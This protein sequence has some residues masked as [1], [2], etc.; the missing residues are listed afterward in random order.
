MGIRSVFA[1]VLLGLAAPA[2]GQS[3]DQE[4]VSV[5]DSPDPV[6]PGGNITYTVTIRNNGP[7]A[8][9][10]GGLNVNLSASLAYV[11]A[12][13]P[14]G[15]SCFALGNNLSCTAPSFAP[16][17][18]VITIVAQ[19]PASLL[20]FPDGTVTSNF[21]TSGVTLDPNIGN[22]Q[23]SSTTDY[24]SP[25]VDLSV[26]VTD[27]PDPVGPNQNL[28]YT[29]TAKNDGPNSAT[30]VNFNVFNNGTLQFKS[31]TAPA[32]FNCAAPAVNGVPTF[33]CSKAAVAPG[34]YPFTVVVYA[35]GALLG[36]NDGTVQTFFGFGGTGNDTNR[37]NDGET[38]TTA[39]VTPDAN[40]SVAVGDTPDPAVVGGEI[41]Y[42]VTVTNLGPDTATSANLNVSNNGLLKFVALDAAAGFN[43]TPPAVGATPTFTC[44]NPSFEADEQAEFI[45]TVRTDESTLG[46]EGGVV[47]T[48]F[49]IGSAL[50]DP[51]NGNNSETEETTVLKNT[52]FRDGFED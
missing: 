21:S 41:E 17:T 33:S 3:A 44:S 13:P 23:K 43:C 2:F 30:D 37:N 15:Y 48:N 42:L 31:V 12:T 18:A 1:C 52:L 28:T 39:Y 45:V 14:A 20:N 6:V 27:S 29:V 35:N 11:S 16:S 5:V 47:S 9:A 36:A 10:N 4:V 50:T 49:S 24:D 19:V 40:L 22:N 26:A 51:V 7:D 32:G 38:E 34:T 8:A 46:V 25:Q